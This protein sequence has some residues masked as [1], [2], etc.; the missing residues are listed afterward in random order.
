LRDIGEGVLEAA[1]EDA[2]LKEGAFGGEI[3]FAG[4]EVVAMDGLV[5]FEDLKAAR[6]KKKK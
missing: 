1:A 3:G 4:G 2:A 6:S 5:A